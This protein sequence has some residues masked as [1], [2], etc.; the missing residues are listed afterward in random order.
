FVVETRTVDLPAG[1]ST[2]QFRGVASTIV[3]DS[4]QIAG[5]PKGGLEGDLDYDLLS[6]GSLLE[7][8]VG[9]QVHLVRTDPKTG[10]ESVETAVVRAASG[11][12]ILDAGGKF[13]ALHCG[14]PPERLVFDEIPQGLT[15][16]PTLSVRTSVPEAGRYTIRLAYIAMRMNWSADY[17]ARVD[18]A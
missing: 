3:P 14:G 8:S 15:G 1:P 10:K 2:V 6:P 9:K 7:H 11:G 17:V 5:L 16:T 18:P 12:A 13:E 4:A